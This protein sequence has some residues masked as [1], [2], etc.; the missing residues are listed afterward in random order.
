MSC[1]FARFVTARSGDLHS[2]LAR[3]PAQSWLLHLNERRKALL[4][5][6]RHELL[7]GFVI[8]KR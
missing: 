1:D 7:A 2:E 8:N 3:K 4:N 6:E 5:V